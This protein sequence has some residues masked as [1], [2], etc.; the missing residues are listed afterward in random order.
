A[1]RRRERLRACRQ[2]LLLRRWTSAC[3]E[4][5]HPL[6][7]GCAT[8]L[9]SPGLALVLRSARDCWHLLR[10]SGD[11]R[12]VRAV[13]ALRASL[14]LWSSGSSE[15][16]RLIRFPEILCRQF[17]SGRQFPRGSPW[18]GSICFRSCVAR[19]RLR[20]APWVRRPCVRTPVVAVA[21]RFALDI[22]SALDG[23]GHTE[24]CRKLARQQQDY[25][26]RQRR[27]LES[28]AICARCSACNL[29]ASAA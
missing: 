27:R 28:K 12:P 14:R 20:T 17:H 16:F 6:L 1:L 2:A 18:R 22:D 9:C 13:Q 29:L 19:A 23:T 25:S 10:V 3:R 4:C 11:L 24:C 5:N 7:S 8:G 21:V 15:F 26:T